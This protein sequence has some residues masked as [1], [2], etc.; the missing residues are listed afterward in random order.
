VLQLPYLG[1]SAEYTAL[2]A[3]TVMNIYSDSNSNRKGNSR[4]QMRING[5]VTLPGSLA[6]DSCQAA[7]DGTK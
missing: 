5:K 1:V 2:G 7:I 3:L 4:K 6:P